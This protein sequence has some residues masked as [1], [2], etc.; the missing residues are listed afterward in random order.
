MDPTDLNTIEHD[1]MTTDLWKEDK[2]TIRND[3]LKEINPSDIIWVFIWLAL[4]I[5]AIVSNLD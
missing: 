4:I 5:W 1:E 2:K 3:K